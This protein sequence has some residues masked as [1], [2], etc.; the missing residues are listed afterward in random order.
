MGK[1]YLREREALPE[2]SLCGLQGETAERKVFM[3]KKGKCEPGADIRKHGIMKAGVYH[4]E[5]GFL[6]GPVVVGQGVMV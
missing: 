5:T 2:I 1:R 4:L 6:I 3:I